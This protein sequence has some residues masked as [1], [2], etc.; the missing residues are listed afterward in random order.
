M[1]TAEINRSTSETQIRVAL[2]LDG[3]GKADISTGIG[4]LDHMLALFAFHARIDLELHAQGDLEVDSHH[5]VEDCALVLGSALDQALGDRKGITRMGAAYVPMDE[6]LARVVID[7][8]G[9]PCSEFQAEWSGPMIGALPTTL[10]EHF[11]RSLAVQ[12]RANLHARIEYGLD[13]HHK[14]E[15]LF[16]ALGRSL[17][18][19]MAFDEG[20]KDGIPST[21]GVL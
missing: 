15:A 7:L 20:F 16:K 3:Q 12:L 10:F 6:A 9:R 14:A 5:T 19:A 18:T 13:D 11:F 8:S 2:T 4:F 1:R 21:K 17:R